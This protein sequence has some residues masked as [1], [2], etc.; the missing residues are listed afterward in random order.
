[1]EPWRVV[2]EWSELGYE[3]RVMNGSRIAG[4]QRFDNE[5]GEPAEVMRDEARKQA[6][7][8]ALERRVPLDC[9]RESTESYAP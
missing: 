3:L 8:L 5:L 4:R 7:E 9:V 1:M 2:Y 6:I